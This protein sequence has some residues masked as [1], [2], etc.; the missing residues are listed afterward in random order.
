MN[1]I[2]VI[3]DLGKNVAT[4][5][6]TKISEKFWEGFPP[7]QPGLGYLYVL[8]FTNGLSKVGSTQSPKRRINEHIRDAWT[9]RVA[10]ADS[11]VSVIHPFYF[12]TEQNLVSWATKNGRATRKEYFYDIGH[13]PLVLTADRWVG[14]ALS[15]GHESK[16]WVKYCADTF[17]LPSAVGLLPRVNVGIRAKTVDHSPLSV[18]RPALS[19][20][21]IRKA[22]RLQQRQVAP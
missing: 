5:E 16:H 20:Q 19:P 3:D 17:R 10:L 6:K 11:W 2:C 15:R 7:P 13:E 1:P 21:T 8:R 14:F 22:R 12:W 9:F 4:S 18:I